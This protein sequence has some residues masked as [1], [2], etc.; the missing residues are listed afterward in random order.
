MVLFSCLVFQYPVPSSRDRRVYVWG[1]SEHG[2]LG[3]KL[4]VQNFRK[5]L[6]EYH[7]KPLRLTFGEQN[8]VSSFLSFKI[9]LGL[10]VCSSIDMLKGS[11]KFKCYRFS[12]ITR[13]KAKW[14]RIFIYC[15]IYCNV[16]GFQNNKV[17]ILL[18]L[19]V[20]F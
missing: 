9:Y 16:H 13:C 18:K 1:L 8:K 3:N 7:Y 17:Q 10:N 5:Q 2:A 19:P 14:I 12:T 20:Y 4:Q 11:R 15:I 6:P